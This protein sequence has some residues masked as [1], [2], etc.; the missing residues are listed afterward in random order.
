[1]NTLFRNITRL[2]GTNIKGNV[3]STIATATPETPATV[4]RD[5]TRSELKR[6]NKRCGQPSDDTQEQLCFMIID[7]ISCIV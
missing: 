6:K 7:C 4:A 3:P 1:M 2:K 5:D